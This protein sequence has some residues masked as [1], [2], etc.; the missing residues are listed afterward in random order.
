M[1]RRIFTSNKFDLTFWAQN[2]CAKFRQNRI[3]MTAVTICTNSVT[4]GQQVI[5]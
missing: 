4:M 2:H 1:G 5:S 3:K